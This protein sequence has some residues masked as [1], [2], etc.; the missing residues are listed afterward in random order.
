M[1]SL[2]IAN[3]F[4]F[5]EST[6]KISAFT[7]NTPKKIMSTKSTTLSTSTTPKP[8]TTETITTTR[9]LY[10]LYKKDELSLYEKQVMKLQSLLSGPQ[11][12]IRSVLLQETVLKLLPNL[13]KMNTMVRLEDALT[14]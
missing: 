7:T 8:M 11:G 4:I 3:Q 6:N 10:N 1:Y 14:G 12:D 5:S 13:K 9:P 2:N